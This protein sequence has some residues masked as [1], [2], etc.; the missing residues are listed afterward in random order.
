MEIV[1]VGIRGRGWK[2]F[3]GKIGFTEVFHMVAEPIEW[4]IALLLA[5]ILRLFS[6]VVIEY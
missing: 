5:Q 2:L 1:L 6:L 3:Y 4:L